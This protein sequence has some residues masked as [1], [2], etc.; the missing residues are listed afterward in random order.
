MNTLMNKK[1][2]KQ[3]FLSGQIIRIRPDPDPKNWR[4]NIYKN[5]EIYLEL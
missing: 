1:N 5:Y 3:F 4:K 2:K